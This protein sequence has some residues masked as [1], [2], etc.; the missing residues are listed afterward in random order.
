MNAINRNARLNLD[1]LSKNQL[2]INLKKM[3]KL[4]LSSALFLF[5]IAVFAQSKKLGD[6]SGKF[7]MAG[8]PFESLVVTVEGE[9]LMADAPGVGKGEIFK[10]DQA[11]AFKEPNNDALIVFK[12]NDAGVVVE[13]VIQVQGSELLGKKEIADQSEFVGKFVFEEG[14]PIPNVN[15]LIKD[16]LLFGD[17]EQ[18]GAELRPTNKKDIFDVIGYDGTAEFSRDSTGKVTV[19]ILNVQGMSMKGNKN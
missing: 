10:T 4:L 13:L 2:N 5:S 8:A 14:S 7:K 11:D 3:K 19:V 16:G 9:S 1:K 17:T 6:Y 18:G 12:R 15:V